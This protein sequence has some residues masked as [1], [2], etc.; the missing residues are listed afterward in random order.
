MGMNAHP[1]HTAIDERRRAAL[2]LL[3][4]L[5]FIAVLVEYKAGWGGD[6][7]LASTTVFVVIA[8][9]SWKRL[10]PHRISVDPLWT[11]RLWRWAW[12]K[13]NSRGPQARPAGPEVRV[14]WPYVAPEVDLEAEFVE[15]GLAE[16]LRG[17]MTWT[18]TVRFWRRNDG[19]P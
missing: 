16:S 13:S 9:I 8:S 7:V 11:T 19:E 1:A 3:A 2:I 15:S 18:R 4:V 12:G 10:S 5:A 6:Q 17:R 14:H